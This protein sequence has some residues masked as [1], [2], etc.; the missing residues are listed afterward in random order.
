MREGGRKG[1]SEELRSGGREEEEE[2][3]LE[4]WAFLGTNIQIWHNK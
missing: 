1:R 3:K 2:E 4:G